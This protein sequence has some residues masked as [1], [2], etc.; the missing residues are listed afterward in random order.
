MFSGEVT[1]NSMRGVCRNSVETVSKAVV[2]IVSGRKWVVDF[3]ES[4]NNLSTTSSTF[5]WRV[6]L[7][8]CH[9]LCS[10][11]LRKCRKCNWNAVAEI[12]I[13]ICLLRSL[14]IRPC[15]PKH[16]S[17]KT[18]VC[19]RLSNFDIWHLHKVDTPKELRV[20]LFILLF[21]NYNLSLLLYYQNNDMIMSNN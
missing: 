14:S 18:R 11:V 9:N 15:M 6:G 17:D 5:L 4:V 13:W 19:M 7:Y 1:S 21:I 8:N 10:L 2:I 20:F 12:V 3:S 16:R